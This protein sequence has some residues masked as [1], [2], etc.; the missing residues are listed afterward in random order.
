MRKIFLVSGL[1]QISLLLTSCFWVWDIGRGFY[2]KSKE[3]EQ[4]F[5]SLNA[6]LDSIDRINEKHYEGRL[7]IS[8]PDD[9][10]YLK[11]NMILEEIHELRKICLDTNTINRDTAVCYNYYQHCQ[12]WKKMIIEKN[13]ADKNIEHVFYSCQLQLSDK[14]PLVYKFA[15]LS[16]NEAFIIEETNSYLKK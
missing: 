16:M 2:K 10:V 3:T 5:D 1:I 11:A 13:K 12:E 4:R 6:L 7:I 15:T 8:K 14:E 9:L